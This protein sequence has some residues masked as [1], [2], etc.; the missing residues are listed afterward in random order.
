MLPKHLVT[1]YNKNISMIRVS[2]L[3]LLIVLVISCK[4]EGAVK[5]GFMVP[6]FELARYEKDKIYFSAKAKELGAEVFVTNADDDEK[7][8]YDQALELIDKGVDVLVV[9]SVNSNTAAAI[10][11]EAHA[12]NV[13]VI[14][15]ERLIQNSDLDYFVA[16]NG[17]LIGKQMADYALKLKP[18]GNYV[19]IGGDKADKNAITVKEGQLNAIQAS[20]A[21]GKIKII[22]NVYIEDWKAENA[23]FEFEKVLKLSKYKPDVVLASNDGMASGVIE[24]LKKNGLAGKVLV[25]GQDADLSACKKIVEGSQTMTVYKPLKKEGEI[26]AEIAVKTAKNEPTHTTSKVFNG[27]KEV[28]SV[29][30]DPIVIDKNNIRSTI[31]ADG[32]HTAKEIYE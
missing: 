3:L 6:N 23:R 7:K 26:A 8:Q 12:R 27:R 28:P 15:Y 20:V 11:R 29:L 22:Y 21:S 24:V 16:F 31:I 2:K 1:F 25:T 13:K 5:L 30:I 17:E 18:E 10:V 32:F 4:R 14:A 9:I 19:L